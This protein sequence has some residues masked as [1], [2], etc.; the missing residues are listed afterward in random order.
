MA[1]GLNFGGGTNNHVRGTMIWRG[2]GEIKSLHLSPKL[3]QKKRV[4]IYSFRLAPRNRGFCVMQSNVHG[5]TWRAP[6]YIQGRWNRKHQ[7]FWGQP[8][9]CP[10]LTSNTLYIMFAEKVP[11]VI[12]IAP[13]VLRPLAEKVPP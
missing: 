3:T 12:E 1:G 11:P 8:Q 7:H 5:C 6:R 9:I 2:G 10:F 4:L 13:L